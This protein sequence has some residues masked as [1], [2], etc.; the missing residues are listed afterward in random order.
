MKIDVKHLA[1]LAR[2]RIEDDRLNQFEKDMES[3]IAMVEQLPQPWS[4]SVTA[5]DHPMKL[6][7]DIV[8]DAEYTRDELL[9][10][11]PETHAGCVVVPRTVE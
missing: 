9:R 8:S 11:A 5:P 10:N 4:G 6:R 3:I 2:L 1:E 7:A